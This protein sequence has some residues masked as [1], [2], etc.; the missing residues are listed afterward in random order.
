[1][2]GESSFATNAT[3][4]YGGEVSIADGDIFAQ[5]KYT[6]TDIL[7]VFGL[8]FSVPF[9]I[10]I[11]RL[12]KKSYSAEGGTSD[13]HRIS[14]QMMFL[15]FFVI[16]A[17]CI[18]HGVSL[19]KPSFEFESR[20]T[21]PNSCLFKAAVVNMSVPIALWLVACVSRRVYVSLSKDKGKFSSNETYML[22]S[23]CP[24]VVT[25]TVLALRDKLGPSGV[26]KP[27][28][29]VDMCWV[30]TLDTEATA[31]AYP[32]PFSAVFVIGYYLYKSLYVLQRTLG[33][34]DEV[35]KKVG[36]KMLVFPLVT[37]CMW[38]PG[39]FY[40]VGKLLNFLPHR[41]LG[42]QVVTLLRQSEHRFLP[43]QSL[44]MW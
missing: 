17:N 36:R 4:Q 38:V 41:A 7:L 24:A 21:I 30:A 10:A 5:F 19:A 3:S 20:A 18:F 13:E 15:L 2:N 32:L 12:S 39:L 8:V 28:D 26:P 40:V 14:Q 42:T 37:F 25:T 43:Q 27:G 23:I 1:M 31:L 9:L 44:A 11:G 33:P 22:V 34:D 35:R 6:V 29:S 16:L